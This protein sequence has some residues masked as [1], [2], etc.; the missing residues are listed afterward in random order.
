MTREEAAKKIE[1][2]ITWTDFYGGW[3]GKEEEALSEAIIALRGPVP[4]PETGLVRCCGCGGIPS[5]IRDDENGHQVI[6]WYG[7]VPNAYP[8]RGCGIR[9]SSEFTKEDAIKAWNAGM[10]YK[11]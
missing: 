10:G 6:C 7:A 4:D 11:G 1:D 2:I 3:G 8:A 5:L 9:T